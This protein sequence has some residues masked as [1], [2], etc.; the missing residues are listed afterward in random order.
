L[1]NP[2][3]LHFCFVDDAVRRRG[4]GRAL[5]Q[6][7]FALRDER[8]PRYTC[9]TSGGAGLLRAVAAL[10]NRMSA[11]AIEAASGVVE[12]RGG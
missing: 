11:Y 5:I 8:A 6:H 7:V 1:A 10:S 2:L 12:A 4:I 9:I 3:T